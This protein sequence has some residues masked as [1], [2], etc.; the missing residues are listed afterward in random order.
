MEP[1]CAVLFPT[2]SVHGSTGYFSLSSA[3]VQQRQEIELLYCMGVPLDA[4]AADCLH[5]LLNMLKLL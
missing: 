3:C 5:L 2:G 4:N 1:P